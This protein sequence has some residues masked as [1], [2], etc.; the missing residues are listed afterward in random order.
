MDNRHANTHL[1]FTLRS[2]EPRYTTMMSEGDHK[3][4]KYWAN[5]TNKSMLETLH[6]LF[7]QGLKCIAEDHEVQLALYPRK[8][9]LRP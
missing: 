1:R 5:K 2:N 6:T 4:L 3:V 8:D 9:D 7:T